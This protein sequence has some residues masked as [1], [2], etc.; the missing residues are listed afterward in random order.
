MLQST[1]IACRSSPVQP[2]ECDHLKWMPIEISSVHSYFVLKL[3]KIKFVIDG[4][5]YVWNATT[6]KFYVSFRGVYD[7]KLKHASLINL[8]VHLFIRLFIC[9]FAYFLLD[10]H[11]LFVIRYCQWLPSRSRPYRERFLNTPRHSFLK[12]QK[13]R[14]IRLAQF[15]SQWIPVMPGELSCPTTSRW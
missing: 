3:W 8:L 10:E 14:W 2:L 6:A 11:N 7:S 15:S 13:S 5:E 12:E 4:H 1:E 9:L